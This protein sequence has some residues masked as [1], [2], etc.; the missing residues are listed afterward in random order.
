M[1]RVH[2]IFFFYYCMHCKGSHMGNNELIPSL[3]LCQF[4]PWHMLY[5]LLPLGLIQLHVWTSSLVLKIR[6]MLEC[7]AV[8]INLVLNC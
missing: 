5:L 6:I 2:S 7:K 8:Q 1:R 4:L 3:Y